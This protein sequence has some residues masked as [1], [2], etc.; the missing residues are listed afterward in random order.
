MGFSSEGELSL[1]TGEK[2]PKQIVFFDYTEQYQVEEDDWSEE[3]V[4]M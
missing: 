1:T 2:V 4:C 3:N